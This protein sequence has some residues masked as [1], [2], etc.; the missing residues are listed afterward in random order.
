MST[1]NYASPVAAMVDGTKGSFTNRAECAKEHFKNNFK[2]NLNYGLIG[3]TAGTAIAFPKATNKIATKVGT[4]FGKVLGKMGSKIANSKIA[5][6]IIKNPAKAGKLAFV[7]VGLGYLMN[8]IQQ[9]A[10][11]AGQI[12]Q[13]YTD[14]AAIETQ[15]KRIV[16]A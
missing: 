10:Y 13:K 12:D 3:A 2:A 11:K 14:A 1:I 8:T 5:Q 4:A 16:L 7:A 9:H 6:S 15:T